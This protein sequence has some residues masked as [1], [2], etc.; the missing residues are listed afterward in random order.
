MIKRGELS[1]A[2]AHGLCEPKQAFGR[3]MRR[4]SQRTAAVGC[5][6]DLSRSRLMTTETN[7]DKQA[8]PRLLG[9][10]EIDAVVGGTVGIH[11]YQLALIYKKC[12]ETLLL[13]GDACPS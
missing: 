13:P 6:T 4:W 3:P 11:A 9:D 7:S 12:Y 5:R 10:T 1:F 8:E 2:S